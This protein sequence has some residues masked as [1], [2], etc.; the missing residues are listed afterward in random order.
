MNKLIAYYFR[1][2]ENYFG[3]TYRRI[4]VGNTERVAKMLADRIGGELFRLEQVQ[5]YSEDYQTCIIEAKADLRRKARPK[6]VAMP[7]LSWLPQLLGNDAR[8]SLHLSGTLRP[9]REDDS[10]V[11]HT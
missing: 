6:L 9:Y 1:A 7:H 2:S 3:G 5:P 8:G 11:L 10:S 4:T